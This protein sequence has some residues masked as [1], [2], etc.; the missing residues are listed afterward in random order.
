MSEISE[1]VARVLDDPENWPGDPKEAVALQRGLADRVRVEPLDVDAVRLVAGLDVSY[2]TDNTALSAAAVV[3]DVRTLEVVE[4]VA[5]SSEPSFPYI[6]GLFGFRESPPVLEALGQLKVTPD[7]YLCDGFGLAHP[8]R[9]GVACHLGVLLDLPVVGSAKSVL[10]G[11]HSVPGEERGSWT[12]MVAGRSEV[13][14][15]SFALADQGKE[16]IG[17]VLR[18][19]RGVKPVYVSVGHRVDLEGAAELVLRLSPKYRVP[20][21]VRHADKLC[22][23]HRKAV[24]AAKEGRAD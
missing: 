10:F 5:I 6:S 3:M 18:T 19:R 7:V 9:F 4:S 1:R 17:R 24:L 2:A 15:D 22:G 12:P 14:P 21:P 20:E 8:R 11:R 13:V 23:E 16:V